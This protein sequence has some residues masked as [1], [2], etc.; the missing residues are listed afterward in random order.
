[1]VCPLHLEKPA[2]EFCGVAYQTK[3]C[4]EKAEEPTNTKSGKVLSEHWHTTNRQEETGPV[5]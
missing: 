4:N 2:T 5:M 1:M 3:N